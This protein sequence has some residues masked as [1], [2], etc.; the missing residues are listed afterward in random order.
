MIIIQLIEIIINIFILTLST[1]L[2]M[3]SVLGYIAIYDKLKK[4]RKE[5]A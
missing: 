5:S 1:F 2:L 3:I 4:R